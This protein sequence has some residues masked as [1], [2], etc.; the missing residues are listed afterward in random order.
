M[1]TARMK[2]NIRDQVARMGRIGL[3]LLIV[4]VVCGGCLMSAVIAQRAP[5][6]LTPAE[7]VSR[8]MV[9]VSNEREQEI[10]TLV[11]ILQERGEAA[12]AAIASGLAQGDDRQRTQLARVLGGIGG[13]AST[14][15]LVEM[16][17]EASSPDAAR[18]ALTA[19][20]NRP[21]RRALSEDELSALVTLV[22]DSSSPIRA[23]SG[24]RV[25]A[26]CSVVAVGERLAPILERFKSE[27][28]SPY[29]ADTRPSYVSPRV[30]VVNQFLLAISYIGAP[31]IEALAQE[32]QAAAANSEIEKWWLIALGVAGDKSVAADLKDMLTEEPD[33]YIRCVAVRAYASSAGQD[34]I[35]LLESL[36]NDTTES[37]YVH[38]RRGKFLLIQ[39]AARSALRRLQNE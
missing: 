10:E 35:P 36:L 29:W 23:G 37:E 31:A 18:R 27:L 1:A 17:A 30:F 8:F 3:Y 13:N 2:T 21:V 28:S 24:A 15:L 7:I 33:R 25:L 12:L 16:L 32:R 22:R 39:S 26:K 19:L 9:A 14:S 5:S 4:V 11:T 38:P 34:A 20:E 6:D